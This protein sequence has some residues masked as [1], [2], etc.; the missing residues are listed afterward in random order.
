MAG[1]Q[2][3]DEQLFEIAKN[4]YEKLALHCQTLEVSGFWEQA[5]QVMKQSGTEVLDV[6]IQSLLMQLGISCGNMP[7]SQLA[8]VQD[9]P[10]TNPLGIGEET[11][12]GD[13][14]VRDVDRAYRMPPILIQL[15]SLYDKERDDDMTGYF[16]DAL[17]NIMLCLS[18]L[19][20]GNLDKAGEFIKEYYNKVSHYIDGKSAAEHARYLFL[21]LNDSC[22]QCHIEKK[23]PVP[24]AEEAKHASSQTEEEDGNPEKEGQAVEDESLQSCEEVDNGE[25]DESLQSCEEFGDGEIEVCEKQEADCAE[26]GRQDKKGAAG[27]DMPVAVQSAEVEKEV[28]QEKT[29]EEKEA[30][31]AA[32]AKAQFL[33]VKKRIQEREFAEEQAHEEKIRELMGELNSLVGLENVKKEIQ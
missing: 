21:K 11:E 18:S 26:L 33:I 12:I 1:M 28:Q 19:D 23:V 8:F 25:E 3:S 13:N 22:I 27:G 32:Q 9:V 14:L 4:H 31:L 30:E 2:Y 6:Y 20:G 7:K 15:C 5:R 29:E 24:D 10:I 16:I 17:L